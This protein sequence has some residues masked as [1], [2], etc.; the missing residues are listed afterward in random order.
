MDWLIVWNSMN[1][2][3]G[4]YGDDGRAVVG[5]S[6]VEESSLSDPSSAIRQSVL[7]DLRGRFDFVTV[8]VVDKSDAV[9]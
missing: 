1:N 8:V 4:V 7:R 6:L 2:M 3:F 5:A 9:G